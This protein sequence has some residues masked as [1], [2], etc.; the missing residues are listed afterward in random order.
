MEK[1][2][3]IHLPAPEA[4]WHITWGWWLL[5]G[6]LLLL[7]FGLYI[8]LPHIQK[9]RNKGLAKKALQHDVQKT[10]ASMRADYAKSH[11]G[12]ALLSD[13]SIFLRRVCVTVFEQD[14]HAGLIQDTWLNFLDKQWEDG[15]PERYFSDEPMAGLLK[16][17]A[18]QADMDEENLE[19]VEALL[20]LTEKWAKVVLTRMD[21]LMV[22][23]HV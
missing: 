23:H 12:L 16:Y 20:E 13:I 21:H 15:K 19:H 17:G 5:T 14:K 4:W 11:N 6:L 7:A 9:W 18:Y 2:K 1:L 8:A 3:D 10:L 22:S